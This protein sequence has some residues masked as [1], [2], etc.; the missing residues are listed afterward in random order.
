MIMSLHTAVANRVSAAIAH[1]LFLRGQS[2]FLY[3]EMKK[4]LCYEIE[5][6][7]PIKTRSELVASSV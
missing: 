4:K 1:R 2:T 7:A 6:L 5:N 3:V